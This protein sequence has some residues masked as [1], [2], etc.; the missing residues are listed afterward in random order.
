MVGIYPLHPPHEG[1]SIADAL[2]SH[3]V[4][5]GRQSPVRSMIRTWPIDYPECDQYW[6]AAARSS[7]PGTT[8]SRKCSSSSTTLASEATGPSKSRPKTFTHSSRSTCPHWQPLESMSVSPCAQVSRLGRVGPEPDSLPVP[9]TEVAW[10]QVLRPGPRRFRAHKSLS[11]DVGAA[12]SHR[13]IRQTP[14]T[15][16]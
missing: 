2:S 10:Q 4:Y 14:C 13:V 16:R 12:P 11:S 6:P 9:F 3:R 7:L 8:S 15:H 5:S 1:T